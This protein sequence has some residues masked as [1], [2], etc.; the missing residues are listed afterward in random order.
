M[1]NLFQ[2]ISDWLSAPHVRFKNANSQLKIVYW[3]LENLK[4]FINSIFYKIIIAPI[5]L[6]KV[7]LNQNLCLDYKKST[8]EWGVFIFKSTLEWG[9]F[10]FKSTLESI[11]SVHTCLEIR[12]VAAKLLCHLQLLK[13][14]KLP[15]AD[16]RHIW[17]TRW[18][19]QNCQKFGLETSDMFYTNRGG[20]SSSS[21][22]S[23]F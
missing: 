10:L 18:S 13:K 21:K 22:S 19:Q 23:S 7:T 4:N 9:V 17:K 11:F 16:Y 15:Q 8:L 2:T 6:L 5:L 12:A 1:I 14:H 3:I 20:G